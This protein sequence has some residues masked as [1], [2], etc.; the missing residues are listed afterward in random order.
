[1]LVARLLQ[2]TLVSSATMAFGWGWPLSRLVGV[3]PDAEVK[4]VPSSLTQ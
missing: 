1:L 3:P 4:T 2:T